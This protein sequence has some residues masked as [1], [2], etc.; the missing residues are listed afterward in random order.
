MTQPLT[1]RRR[2]L[3]VRPR[4][5]RSWIGERRYE[6]DPTAGRTRKQA[7]PR[8]LRVVHGIPV[9]YT[10]RLDGDPDPG[11]VV[12]TWVPYRDDATR[13]KDRPVVVIGR[14]GDVLVAV[15]VTS[16]DKGRDDHVPIGSGTWDRR[17][18]PS[19]A[20]VDRLITVDADDVRKE[21]GVLSRP[22]FEDVVEGVRAYHP[23]A[24]VPPPPRGVS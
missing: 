21:G 17:R 16:K 24:D 18:R 4:S 14:S 11:E 22:M 15:P 12:W 10:P 20:K 13:G 6:Y 1:A 7:A 9:R 8:T 2:W 3:F 23:M 5:G 19:F